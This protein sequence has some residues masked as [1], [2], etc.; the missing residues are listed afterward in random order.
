MFLNSDSI[1]K[2]VI[3][4]EKGSD[5]FKDDEKIIKF[6]DIKA[7]YYQE[8]KQFTNSVYE[9][10]ELKFI[11]YLQNQTKPYIIKIDSNKMINTN[12]YIIYLMK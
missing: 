8:T 12:K 1:K 7:F 5:Y 4:F 10:N 6:E 11:L 9:G 3:S 2:R